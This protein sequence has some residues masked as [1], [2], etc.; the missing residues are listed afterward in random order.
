MRKN[1]QNQVRTVPRTKDYVTGGSADR[2]IARSALLV[3][4]WIKQALDAGDR[5]QK[6]SAT[7]SCRVAGAAASKERSR[8]LPPG[9]P[10]DVGTPAAWCAERRRRKGHA[11]P[12]PPQLNTENEIIT[13]KVVQWRRKLA[14]WVRSWSYVPS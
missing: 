7:S 2:T 1:G 12:R 4:C 11:S 14:R 10:E 6:S 13:Y 3:F 9:R 5:R 8:M